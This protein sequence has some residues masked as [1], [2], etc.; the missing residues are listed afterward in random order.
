MAELKELKVRYIIVHESV[1]SSWLK[2]AGSLGS[3]A[4]L[5]YVNHQ[6]GNGS[7]VVD[8]VGALLLIAFLIAK[9]TAMTRYRLGARAD[10]EDAS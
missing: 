1:F 10:G 5:I 9:A 3:L 7:A 8:G 2:D 4:G 6:F